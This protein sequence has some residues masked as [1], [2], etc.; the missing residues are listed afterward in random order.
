MS[1]KL[2]FIDLFAGAGGLSEG[3]IRAGYEP[4]AHVEA[5]RAAC[6]TLKTRVAYHYL[7]DRGELS[8][9]QKYLKGEINRMEFYSLIPDQILSSVINKTISNETNKEIFSSIDCIKKGREVDLII[10]GP[11][12]QAYST[13]GRGALKHKN[14]DE[15]KKLFIEYGKYLAYYK[16]KLFVFENVPGLK[17][18]DGGVYYSAIK[19]YFKKLGYF[20]DERLLDARDFGVVQQRKR[21]IIVGWRKDI[22]FS[23]PDFSPV[24]WDAYRDDIFSDLPPL[25]PGEG[26]RWTEYSSLTNCYLEKSYIRNGADFTTLHIARPHNEKD[27]EIYKLAIQ[28][29]NCGE[30]IKN[31]DIPEFMR[32]QKNVEDFLDR[33]KVVDK[34]PHTMIA[35]IAKD[36]HHFIHP[37]IEQLRSISVREAARIQSFPDDFYFEGVKENQ[38][39]SAAYKQIGNAVPPLM[40]EKIAREIKTII[41]E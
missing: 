6:F 23:Y 4:I 27:L 35:H 24:K 36:G 28:R 37:S 26:S 2:N 5:D 9:Y 21:L 12:C 30:R 31:S 10:G 16:P 39:R 20:V 22:L 18:S 38:N 41:N 3:F 17:S 19:K 13:T 33:F 40:A 14:K 34:L 7:R 8:S 25:K 32:T 1:K 15:R 11:P 29:I